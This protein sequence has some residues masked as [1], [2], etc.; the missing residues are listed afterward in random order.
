ML[1]QKKER[2]TKSFHWGIVHKKDEKVIGEM[3]GYRIEN[4][5]LAKVAFRL[6]PSYQGNGLMAEALAEAV[7]FCFEKTEIQ[8][9]G[10]MFTF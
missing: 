8:V 7:T 1:F 6:S 5:R 2:P 3:W 9:Y 10:P 4:D